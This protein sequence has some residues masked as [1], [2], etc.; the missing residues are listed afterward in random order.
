MPK[1]SHHCGTATE[2]AELLRVAA[3]AWPDEFDDEPE[4]AEEAESAVVVSSCRICPPFSASDPGLPIGSEELL[5]VDSSVM[6]DS[7]PSFKRLLSSPEPDSAI[8]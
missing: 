7:E 1:M 6:N 2:L 8:S 4:L 3:R 5:L